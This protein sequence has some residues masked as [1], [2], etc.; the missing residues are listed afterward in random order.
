[1]TFEATEHV[2]F[3]TVLSIAEQQR[4]SIVRLERPHGIVETLT[5]LDEYGLRNRWIF[6]IEGNSITVARRIER[7]NDAEPADQWF[8]KELVCIGY[9]YARER[10]LFAEIEEELSPSSPAVVAVAPLL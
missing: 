5:P 9:G 4:W 8:L 1:M 6:K 10:I 2:L 7:Q 3:V